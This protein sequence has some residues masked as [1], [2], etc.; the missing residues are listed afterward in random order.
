MSLP[1][2]NKL[3][4][5]ELDS[6]ST[7]AP[8]FDENGLLTAIVMDASDGALLMVAYMNEEAIS[9]TLKTGIAHYYS[10]SRAKIWKKGETSGETQ[11]LV[12]MRTDCDQDCIQLIVKQ[13]G[14]GSA[15]HTGRKSCFY[16]TITAEDGALK[17][18]VNDDTVLFDPDKVYGK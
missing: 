18:S 15:C 5:S 10:R 1:D 9:L 12:E 14:R 16:R 4:K 6:T 11:S 8:R 7:F 13:N 3:S 2:G 17:L